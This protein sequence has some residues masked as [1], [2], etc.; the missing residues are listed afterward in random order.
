MQY[1][2]TQTNGGDLPKEFSE[3]MAVDIDEGFVDESEEEEARDDHEQDGEEGLTG[4]PSDSEHSDADVHVQ[5]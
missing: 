1:L 5:V 2:L 3:D 4:H